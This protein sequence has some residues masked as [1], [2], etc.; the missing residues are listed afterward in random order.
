MSE[1]YYIPVKFI[2]G[3]AEECYR[4]GLTEKQ[5]SFVMERALEKRADNIFSRGWDKFTKWMDGDKVEE[6]S[7][8]L[9]Q[10]AN[11]QVQDKENYERH[12][13][14]AYWRNTHYNDGTPRDKPLMSD[15]EVQATAL[16]RA[17][18]DTLASGTIGASAQAKTDIRHIQKQLDELHPGDVAGR[19]ALLKQ[20][21]AAKKRAVEAGKKIDQ[22]HERM[23]GGY[24]MGFGTDP[25][26]H[27]AADREA[28]FA[29]SNKAH[30]QRE[31]AQK[32]RD[33]MKNAWNKLSFLHPGTWSWAPWN[34]AQDVAN[35]KKS[36]EGASGW[37]QELHPDTFFV[38]DN[39]EHNANLDRSGAYSRAHSARKFMYDNTSTAARARARDTLQRLSWDGVTADG[40]TPNKQWRDALNRQDAAM[41]ARYRQGY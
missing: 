33:T 28:V 31:R 16:R 13:E 6:R 22:A 14:E 2:E 15:D 24:D 23:L 39:A 40:W 18:T 25:T 10:N 32:G 29:R 4:Q 27:Y 8:Q 38:P 20:Q 11:R 34:N 17:A 5:A 12:L 3:V 9:V 7:G 1:S 30:A 41:Q 37:L 26:A 19:A 21:E 36:W 35:A